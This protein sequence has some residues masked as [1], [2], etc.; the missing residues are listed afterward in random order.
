MAVYHLPPRSGNFSWTVNRKNNLVF[1]DWKFPEKKGFLWKVVQNYQTE[2]YGAFYLFLQLVP[3]LSSCIRYCGNARGNG[4][5]TSHG[6]SHSVGF[7][8]VPFITTF[9]QPVLHVR[10][11]VDKCVDMPTIINAL[12]RLAKKGD[13]IFY[14]WKWQYFRIWQVKTI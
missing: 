1:P 9:D 3:G 14:V 8:C 2:L 12:T 7:W 10:G 13:K 6:N 4:L 5:C 11:P